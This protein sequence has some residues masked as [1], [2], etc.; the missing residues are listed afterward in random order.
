MFAFLPLTSFNP[1]QALP[2]LHVTPSPTSTRPASSSSGPSPWKRVAGRMCATTSCA[3]ESCQMEGA[4][5][6]AAPTYAFCRAASACRTPPWWWP[7]CSRTPTTASCWRPSTAC[8]SWPRS[9]QSSMCHLMWPPIRQVSCATSV[10]TVETWFMF[11]PITASPCVLHSAQQVSCFSPRI[12][13]CSELPNRN[14]DSFVFLLCCDWISEF[15]NKDTRWS[16]YHSIFAENNTC[17][18][19]TI[20]AVSEATL[21]GGNLLS[22]VVFAS[23]F[24]VEKSSL[25]L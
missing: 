21:H 2:L 13:T 7:T 22:L 19:C 10:K 6:N 18:L 8:Q 20:L 3:N 17:P 25:V 23:R 11:W 4:W 1:S 12:Q 16:N 14:H 9:T 5:R 15:N 24:V